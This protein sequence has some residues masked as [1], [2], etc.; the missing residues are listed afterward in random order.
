MGSPFKGAEDYIAATGTIDSFTGHPTTAA[1]VLVLSFVLTCYFL[2][3]SYKIT[4]L[5]K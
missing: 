1:I 2:Y 5:K 4:H 3:A